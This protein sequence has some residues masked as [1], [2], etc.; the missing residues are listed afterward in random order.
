VPTGGFNFSGSSSS[1]GSGFN[2]SPGSAVRGPTV[3]Q[4]LQLQQALKQEHHNSLLGDIAHG[5]G[6]GLGFALDKLSRPAYAV[7]AGTFEGLAHDSVG[8]GLHGAR[9]GFMGREKKTF[10]DVIR[11]QAPE[12][13]KKHKV[14][15]AAGGFAAD[16]LTDPSL[17]LILAS[18]LIPG[19]GEAAD[20]AYVTRLLGGIDK[21]GAAALARHAASKEAYNALR[22]M[23]PEWNA[24]KNLALHNLV[25][26]AGRLQGIPSTTR[27]RALLD[28]AQE[29]AKQE[30]EKNSVK[31][32]QARYS[33]PFSGG[34]YIP[35][36]PTMIA[37][38]RVAPKVPDLKRAAEGAGILGKIPGVAP[39]AKGIGTLFRHGFNEEE[40]AKPALMARRVSENLGDQYIAH[41][42]AHVGRPAGLSHMSAEARQ[43]AI[44]WA[45]SRH[46]LLHGA[47][48][49]DSGLI[50]RAVQHGEIDADQAKYIIG[51]HNHMEMLRA[52][53]AE[54]GVKYEKELGNAFYV[55]HKY[56]RDGGV[57]K[58]SEMVNAGF[59]KSRNGASTLKDIRESPIAAGMN[60]VTD[61]EEILTRRTREGA[62]KHANA[63]LMDHMRASHGVIS[64]VPDIA[65]RDKI[66]Q[67]IAEH[68]AKAE[69]VAAPLLDRV[70]SHQTSIGRQVEIAFKKKLAKATAKRDARL[71]MINAG[72]EHHAGEA[73][74]KMDLKPTPSWSNFQKIGYKRLMEHTAH[75]SK[76]DRQTAGRI[77][78]RLALIKK[79]RNQIKKLE[80]AG[81][82]GSKYRAV[83]EDFLKQINP[84]L[85]KA[86]HKEWKV[87]DFKPSKRGE[88]WKQNLNVR[89]DAYEAAVKNQWGGLVKKYP[90]EA[91]IPHAAIVKRMAASRETAVREHAAAV[92]KALDEAIQHQANL[93]EKFGKQFERDAKQFSNIQSRIEK[94]DKRMDKKWMNNPD[95]PRG[96]VLLDREISGHKF[97]FA[98]EIHKAMARVETA[99]NNDDRML[100]LGN[101]ARKLMAN[102][103]IGVTSVNP[104]YRIRNTMSDLWNMYIAGVPTPMIA[105]YGAKAASL[106]RTVHEAGL[107]LAAGDTNLSKR[108]INALNKFND[109]YNHGILSGLFQGDIQQVG[110]MMRSGRRARDYINKNPLSAGRAYVKATQ[111]MN[112]HAENWGRIT[113]YLYRHDYQKLGAAKS[114]EWVKK[115]HF[116][117]EELTPF[118]Q[119]KL[120]LVFPFY[121]WTR[122]NIP[123]QLMQMVSRPGKYATLPKIIRTSNELATGEPFTPGNQE[124][125]MPSWMRQGFAFRVPGGDNS[126]MLPQFGPSDFRLFSNPGQDLISLSNPAFKVAFEV[127]TGKSALTGQSIKGDLHPRNPISGVAADILRDVPG[128][129]V[130]TT[131]RN[132][133]GVQTFGEG[134]NPW[135]GY[136]AGQTPMT[137]FLVNQLSSIK[138]AQRGKANT[139]AGYLGGVSTYERDLNAEAVAANLQFAA[140]MKKIM[141]GYRDEGLLPNPKY[142]QPKGTAA[143]IQQLVTGT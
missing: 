12:W 62:L 53:D 98:P 14:L 67:R 71:D 73:L 49:L 114:A 33:I 116:D 40:Y 2:F 99:V 4:F 104:G 38:V 127:G 122:K 42:I 142:K 138:E 95:V 96:Y 87:E 82:H 108:E 16:I 89:L 58:K 92:Q 30:L 81:A 47:R 100:N 8:A 90:N 84:E 57:V 19:V 94:L 64:R 24:S 45:E 119:Q 6:H 60:I 124:S 32:M 50:A 28:M 69:K 130:G 29:S 79:W 20:A 68:Q 121:T 126:Y 101:T 37:G 59:A 23:G 44:D 27:E 52:K 93:K 83:V 36:T 31:V 115:A 133:R 46:D 56:T 54:F 141:R 17:P 120:K 18:N 61:P 11:Q 136:I 10:S 48:K 66:A 128:A 110:E 39:A 134:A 5:A 41:A 129:N 26:S 105:H 9:E 78:A 21:A 118:E 63:A 109:M 70:R 107:K 125:T 13:A 113:H 135:V 22:E 137:N 72:I 111:D 102:W 65:A 86:G 131:S 3:S 34:K 80:D 106:Q 139:Y 97:Y 140:E 143:Q 85:K 123:Y 76:E 35:L 103:K 91:R 15:T 43:H 112:R 74:R 55:P 117:Y 51:W 7:A 75:F 132:V 88:T 1:R 77:H 25:Q